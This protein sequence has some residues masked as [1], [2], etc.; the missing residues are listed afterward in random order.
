MAKKKRG[1]SKTD[2]NKSRTF[3]KGLTR[4]TDPSFIQDGMW[5]YARN[6][7]NNTKEGDLG[8]LSNEESNF[9]CA[10]IGEDITIPHN[11]II[12]G[13]IPLFEGKW[14][15]Y[16]AIYDG[17]NDN[18]IT[19]EIGLFEEE[20]CLYRPIVRDKCLNFNKFNLISGASREKEDCSW[21]IY[22]ADGL[23]PD[24]YINI[25][26]PRLWPNFKFYDWL[27][28]IDGSATVN[29]YS[30]GTEQ[31]L[32][33][34]VAW[35]EEC[36]EVDSCTICT[37]TNKL[38]CNAI[39]LASLVKTPCIDV[40]TSSQQGT[41][42]NGSYA[43]ALA[44][45]INRQIVT[46]FFSLSY[47]Q[48]IFND[49]NERGALDLTIDA[50][51]EHFDEFV[52][53]A[54]RFINQNSS[55]KQIG[56]FSTKNTNITLDQISETLPNVS[57]SNVLQQNPVFETS[58]QITEASRYLLR[59]GPI[60]KFDFNYQPLANK[61]NT[62]W[63]SVEYPEDYYI[64]GGKNAGYM[65]DEVYAFFIRWVYDTGDKSSSYHIPGRVSREYNTPFSG[66]VNEVDTYSDGNTLPGEDFLFETINT[67]TYTSNG[68]NP[69]PIDSFGGKI[70]AEGDMGYWQSTERYPDNQP[71]IWNSSYYCWTKTNGTDFDLCGKPIRHHKFPDN[72]VDQNA[73]HFDERN[74]QYFIRLMGVSFENII[75]PKDNDGNDIEGIVGYEI[76]RSSRH[77]N[78]SIVAKG[79]VNNFRDYELQGRTNSEST[80]GLYAN[81]PFN[82]IRPLK[83]SSN[84]NNENY[85]FNDPYI[86]SRSPEN[87]TLNPF[88]KEFI[89]QS[90]PQDLVSFH[91]PDTSF[92][93]PFLSMSELKVYGHLE[94]I[95]EQRFI[96][97]N[98]HPKFK[99]LSNGVI[100]IGALGGL[101][102]AL[103]KTVGEVKVNYPINPITTVPTLLAGGTYVPNPVTGAVAAAD[104]ITSAAFISYAAGGAIGDAI[105]G[106]DQLQVA[107]EAAQVAFNGLASIPGLGYAMPV[108]DKVYSPYELLPPGLAAAGGVGQ[109]LFYVIEGAQVTIRL[110]YEIIRAQQYALEQISHGNYNKWVVPPSNW[111]SRFQMADGIYVFNDVQDFPEFQN[112]AGDSVRYRINNRK[113]PR[114]P[115]LRTESGNGLNIGPRFIYDG[116][117]QLDPSTSSIDTSLM[118]L[119][120]AGDNDVYGQEGVGF[121]N[122]AKLTPFTNTIAS[123]YAGLKFSIRNQYGQLESI[124]QIIATPCEQD[125]DFNNLST[126]NFGNTVPN[127][128]N[129][130]VHNKIGKTPVFFGGDTYVNRFT[131]KNIMPFFYNWLFDVSENTPYNYFLSPLV[132]YPRYWANSEPWD[133][134]DLYNVSNLID[135]ITDNDFGSGLTPGSYYNLDG[136]GI[137]LFGVKNDYF[138]LSN[139]GI[140][141]FFVESEVLVDFRSRGTFDYEE[142]YSKYKFTDLEFLFDMNPEIIERGNK[143]IYDYSLSSSRFVFNQ[144]FTQGVLQNKTYNPTV[145]DLCFTSYPNRIN[146]SLPQVKEDTTDGWLTYLPLNNVTFRNDVNSVKNY[147]KT[148]IFITFEDASPLVYQGVD[149]RET[150]VGVA[151]TVGD[152]GL[153]AATPV[154]VTP[155]DKKYEYGSSQD[156]LGII[157]SPAGLY[158]ISQQQ[159][160]IFSYGQ[161]LQEISQI[162]M[163]WWFNEF[164]PYK[165]IEDFPE[166]PH[167]DNPVAG[168]GC[169][170]GYDNT[171]GI[172]YF[173][174]KDYMLKSKYRGMVEYLEKDK[175]IYYMSDNRD[176]KIIITLGDARFFEDA[177]W[178]ISYDPKN[179]QWISFHDWH[180]N[181]YLSGRNKHYT[182]KIGSIWEHNAGCNDYCNFYNVQYP[183]EIGIP[184]NTG[185]QVATIRSLE[186]YLECYK[187]DSEFCVDQYHVLDYNFDQAVLFNSEQVS[188][189]LNLNIYPKN[190]VALAENYPVIN[191]GSVDILVS[192]EEQK[193]RFNQFW[194]ITK[195][196]GEFPDGSGYPPTGQLIPN[197][198]RL[199]GNYEENQIWNTKANGYVQTLNPVNLNY[200]KNQL[201]RKRFRHYNNFVKLI[202]NNPQDVNMIVKFVEMKGLYSPR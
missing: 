176:N 71:E 72:S 125:I 202:K 112:N 87:Q 109:F 88:D 162:N 39:R 54:V 98:G 184:F 195:D 166:F 182:T 102:N 51:T 101:L 20:G 127:C 189:Y 141:D 42:E 103:L 92:K 193:Y 158:F 59:I 178:T 68:G 28:G 183:F 70:I 21:Q 181:L 131:E 24:R 197:T 45:V 147:S 177:S 187:R 8:T 57:E 43:F 128:V 1:L 107:Y 200:N 173:S 174:K 129:P 157:S 63:V 5:T 78:R 144:Y 179:K 32:W 153:F 188:G 25:G 198:T 2:I 133:F 115:V 85:G 83:N 16:S 31:I 194:D 15:I 137:N 47:I 139:N 82:C 146:Y 155:S 122:N 114:I 156:R 9:L 11:S 4:D 34:G 160:K 60:S 14:V 134:A 142:F 130:L 111:P 149:E 191:L 99:L 55:L 79:M 50:D 67:A 17:Q 120:V 104:A 13:A 90:L 116:G 64:K 159:G 135:T 145:A 106:T 18:V 175:F 19:S 121:G 196:R 180:P 12:I 7:V 69:E 66:T 118:T 41:I 108:Y 53:V 150:Y 75:L 161:G 97:P 126:I 76:L 185:K 132:P 172:I 168:I 192:K 38:D 123:N 27:G 93:R 77:G 201:Q 40:T 10:A 169:S 73:Y 100:I 117:N 164:L 151:T 37:L 46:N 186:Y 96:E 171:D 23:N 94:G 56:Y 65:R 86:L 84:P 62:K 49:V 170:A 22:W 3:L 44:Y 190:N 167:I 110:V 124:Q 163:K 91:S 35:I 165:L 74:G 148:G 26:D 6:A 113:R 143:Y 152:G 95:A 36:N 58:K 154:N 136:K 52:L 89:N 140:R 30:N 199:L 48:P 80:I 29:Y 105:A 33:P 81:Y 119:G 138:Y 61:I